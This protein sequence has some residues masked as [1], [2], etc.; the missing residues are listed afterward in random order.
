MTTQAN[1]VTSRGRSAPPRWTADP[2]GHRLPSISPHIR[3]AEPAFQQPLTNLLLEHASYVNFFAPVDVA[4]RR[5][6]A[7]RRPQHRGQL[8]AQ[9]CVSHW[10]RVPA[11][12]PGRVATE[13]TLIGE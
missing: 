9:G 10:P 4:F 7:H 12:S 11:D 8:S 2:D 13:Q 6:R 3:A 1:Q 5:A